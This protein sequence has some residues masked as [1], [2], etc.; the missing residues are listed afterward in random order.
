MQR[1]TH[2]L[3]YQAE[4]LDQQT[5]KIKK[6]QDDLVTK[7]GRTRAQLE[8]QIAQES[9]ALKGMQVQPHTVHPAPLT[10]IACTLSATLDLV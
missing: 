9:S 3:P 7:D 8:A 1:L 10:C 2:G 6:L 5:T 4:A